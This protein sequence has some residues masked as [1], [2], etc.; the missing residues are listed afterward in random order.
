M[1]MDTA[2]R[3]WTL[4]ERDRLPNDGNRYEVVYGELF[5]TPMPAPRHQEIVKR[6]FRILDAFVEAHH[7]GSAYESGT[8]VIFDEH[9]GVVPD[10]AVYSFGPDNLPEHWKDAPKPMLVVEVCSDATWRRDVGPKR[11]LYVEREVPE[12][13]IVDGDDCEVRVVRPGHDD[14]V[15]RD[16]LRWQPPNADAA[17]EIPLREVFR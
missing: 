8:D 17:L 13:W 9:N 11:R 16:V 2:T 15:V 7:I 6:M 12:Y 3:P 14:V 1:L 10:V 5:V 4:A